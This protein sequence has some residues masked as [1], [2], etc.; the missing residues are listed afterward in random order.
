MEGRLEGGMCWLGQCPWCR[1]RPE[2]CTLWGRRTHLCFT[3]TEEGAS[4]RQV[5]KPGA[6]L[7]SRQPGLL[8]VYWEMALCPQIHLAVISLWAATRS[9]WQAGEHGSCG[10][11]CIQEHMS[12]DGM[13]SFY[14]Y[15]TFVEFTLTECRCQWP[16]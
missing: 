6:S 11:Q 4:A 14:H 7:C 8:P 5:G 10:G 3:L 2:S 9:A 13:L 12:A 15:F 1:L 16:V